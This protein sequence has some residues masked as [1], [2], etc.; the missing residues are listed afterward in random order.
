MGASTAEYTPMRST[1][2]PGK[3]DLLGVPGADE[4]LAV[5]VGGTVGSLDAVAVLTGTPATNAAAAAPV[6]PRSPRRRIASRR[7][8]APSAQS[9]VIS[10]MR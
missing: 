8:S 1:F 2:R 6:T 5:S 4:T 7:V 9:M 10:S 3:R